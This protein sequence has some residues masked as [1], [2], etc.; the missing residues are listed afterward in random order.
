M[1]GNPDS[2]SSPSIAMA[3][4]PPVAQPGTQG[5]AASSRLGKETEAERGC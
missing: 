3:P 4:V 5:A 2:K 1:G